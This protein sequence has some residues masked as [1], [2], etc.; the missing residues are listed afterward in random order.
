MRLLINGTEVITTLIPRYTST[1]VAQ[2]IC[3]K[4]WHIS[5]L[6]GNPT[7]D[8]NRATAASTRKRCPQ[9]IQ[10]S[11]INSA[12]MFSSLLTGG[13]NFGLNTDS[14]AGLDSSGRTVIVCTAVH[15][16]RRTEGS[17]S[18]LDDVEWI[19]SLSILS[20]KRLAQA[21]RDKPLPPHIMDAEAMGHIEVYGC[22]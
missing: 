12:D 11:T 20:P 16:D 17:D 10:L 8:L 3:A 9:N 6:G 14:N 2:I 7:T 19:G 1:D 5:R 21:P 18:P 15:G 4:N 13:T 22:N